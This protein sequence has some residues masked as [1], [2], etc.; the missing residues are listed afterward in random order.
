MSEP[1][2][3]G[4]LN[5]YEE[6]FR[7]VVA[8]RTMLKAYVQAIVRDPEGAE[9]TLSDVC[10]EIARNWE[11]YDPARPFPE[12]ARGLARRVALAN[13]RKRKSQPA[14]LDAEALEAVG[15]QI[16]ALGNEAQLDLRKQALRACMNSLS[17]TNRELIRLRYF[18]NQ[19]FE[20]ISRVRN[21]N[22][23]ALYVSFHRLH[24]ALLKCMQSRLE[25]V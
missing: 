20:E 19:S 22:V 14:L 2:P 12:W 18:E 21:R 4:Q 17:E 5:E 1:N 11:R 15:V 13:L 25:L 7:Q 6:A 9:D 16:D 23:N 24:E 10:V 3:S 8:H